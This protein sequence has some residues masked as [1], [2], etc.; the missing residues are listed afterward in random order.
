MKHC[1][2]HLA[3]YVPAKF[4]AVTAKVKEMHYQ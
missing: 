4:E 3:T 1:P 2:L